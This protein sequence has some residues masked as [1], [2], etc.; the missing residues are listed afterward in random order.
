MHPS[1][2]VEQHR[3]MMQTRLDRARRRFEEMASLL[4]QPV[5]RAFGAAETQRVE[6]AFWH[7][8]SE[9]RIVRHYF[10]QWCEQIGP[11]PAN[12]RMDGW[13]DQRLAA[14]EIEVWNAIHAGQPLQVHSARLGAV[15][16]EAGQPGQ[17]P[18]SQDPNLVARTYFVR[19][20]FRA[21]EQSMEVIDFCH[22]AL[23]M[24][25]QFIDEFDLST[26]R[27]G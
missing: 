3:A 24:V 26:G 23:A 4:T 19:Y 1:P 5:D 14:D 6:E 20:T 15:E 13:R 16:P 18:Q 21:S 2:P 11:K 8:L 25:Q 7:I 27:P 22:S 12:V 17:S 9:M 10:G